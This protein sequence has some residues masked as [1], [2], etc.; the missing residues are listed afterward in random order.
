MCFGLCLLFEK[1]PLSWVRKF[2]GLVGENS[3]EIY[4]LNVSMFFHTELWRKVIDFGP[5]NRLY[6]LVIFGLNIVCGI[7][8]HRLVGIGKKKMGDVPPAGGLLSGGGK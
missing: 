4:L 8:L 1:L 7:G 2:L 6:W 3:L 5:T